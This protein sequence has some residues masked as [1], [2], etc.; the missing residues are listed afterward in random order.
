[1]MI[2]ATVRNRSSICCQLTP[3]KQQEGV[4]A[5]GINTILTG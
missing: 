5:S 4:F 1:M 2:D 3:L